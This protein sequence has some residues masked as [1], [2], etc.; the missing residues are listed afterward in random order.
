MSASAFLAVSTRRGDSLAFC[1]PWSVQ[2]AS[3][4]YVGMAYLPNLAHRGSAGAETRSPYWLWRCPDLLRSNAVE[5]GRHDKVVFVQP[6]DLFG[7]QRDR[8]KPPTKA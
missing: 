1:A 3:M 6:F 8:R 2:F 4:M 5:L 7:L